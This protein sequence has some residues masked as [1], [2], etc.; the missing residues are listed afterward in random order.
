MKTAVDLPRPENL[1]D[2]DS[3]WINVFMANSKAEALDWVRE[4]VGPC[5][6]DGNVNVLTELPGYD[7]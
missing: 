2:N 7:S 6:D 5:D 4:H 3:S 1:D